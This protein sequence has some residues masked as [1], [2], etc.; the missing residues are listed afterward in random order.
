MKNLKLPEYVAGFEIELEPLVAVAKYGPA[1]TALPR[2]PKVE[3]DICLRV[4]SG[5][6]YQALADVVSVAFQDTLPKETV[7]TLTPLDIY[8]AE[9][10]AGHKQVTFRVAIAS[11]EQTLTDEEVNRYLDQVAHI[12]QEKVGAERV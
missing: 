4:D 11:Y 12:A 9:T 1:Y 2:F 5:V 10:D 7:H 6:S 8:A 3:Q